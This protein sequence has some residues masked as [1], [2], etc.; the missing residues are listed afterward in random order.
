[1]GCDYYTY[2]ITRI[3]Y[4]DTRGRIRAHDEEGQRES[5]YVWDVPAPDPDL[6]EPVGRGTLIKAEIDRARREYGERELFVG[7]EWKCQPA[8][9]DRIL[10][11]C[12]QKAI[13]VEALVR[14]YKFKSGHMR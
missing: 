12:A 8:G 9:K 4:T 3:Q 1:M 6:E 5:H 10:A 14:I 13:P 2:V 11:L 7:G